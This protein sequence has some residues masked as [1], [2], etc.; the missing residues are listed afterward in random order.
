[1]T[2]DQKMWLVFFVGIFMNTLTSEEALQQTY[3][4]SMLRT[5]QGEFASF[6]YVKRGIPI[7][8]LNN[9]TVRT[10]LP[11]DLVIK[12]SKG[13]ELK[14]EYF[15]RDSYFLFFKLSDATYLKSITSVSGEVLHESDYS[16]ETQQKNTYLLLFFLSLLFLFVPAVYGACQLR[17][18][19]N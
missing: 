10:F 11:R 2:L 14:V 8:K 17:K 19:Y 15:I 5:A 16:Y 3:N 7:L 1:M 9:F 4:D 18:R 13:Q 12:F 6:E